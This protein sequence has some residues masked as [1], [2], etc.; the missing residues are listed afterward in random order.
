MLGGGTTGVEAPWWTPNLSHKG[1]AERPVE[2][3]EKTMTMSVSEQ[4]LFL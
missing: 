4:I 3:K 1:L 2:E